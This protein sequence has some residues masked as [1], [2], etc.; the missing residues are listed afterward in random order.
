[1]TPPLTLAPAP[2]PAVYLATNFRLKEA[3]P[4][5]QRIMPVPS[6]TAGI[7]A[8]MQRAI[9]PA[10]RA[11][12]H[13]GCAFKINSLWRPDRWNAACGGSPRSYHID[14]LA[15]DLEP[16]GGIVG[17]ADVAKFIAKM[18]DVDLTILEFYRPDFQLLE[19]GEKEGPNSGWTHYQVAKPGAE[20]RGIRLLAVGEETDGYPDGVAEAAEAWRAAQRTP[21]RDDLCPL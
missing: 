1:M 6:V 20:P 17:N 15:V 9:V 13:F 11:R 5:C 21:D 19:G 7:L 2:T 8:N 3:L 4:D 14:A 18:Y 10:Q 12:D 16:C